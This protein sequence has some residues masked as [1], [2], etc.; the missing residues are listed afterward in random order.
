MR[1][2]LT[3][4]LAALAALA[5]P[6]AAGAHVTVSPTETPAQ[7]YAMLDFTVPHGCDGAATTRVTI[8]MP[9]QVISATPEEV[10]GWK[11]KTKEGKLPEPAEQHGETVTE[12]VREVSWTG[13]PLPDAHLQRFGLSVALA[14]EAGEE[15]PFK[16]IQDCVGGGETAW[17]QLA[18]GDEE[19]EHP[20]PTVTLTAADDGHGADEAAAAEHAA[21]GSDDDSGKGIAIAALIVGAVGVVLGAFALVRT[22]RPVS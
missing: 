17:V 10:P 21:A 4:F 14:G 9:P 12:G 19:P 2:R 15:V 8:Q 20:A 7:G 18:S 5:L 6:A 22:R 16:A 1:I 11:I 3:M 13:G